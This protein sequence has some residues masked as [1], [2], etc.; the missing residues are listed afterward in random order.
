MTEQDKPYSRNAEILPSTQW[1]E[2]MQRVAL[3]VE[4]LGGQYHGFQ[5]QPSGV[6]TVQQALEHALSQGAAE[7]ITL[8]CAGRTDAGLLGKQQIVGL[9]ALLIKTEDAGEPRRGVQWLMP[10]RG[11]WVRGEGS[12]FLPRV[13][14]KA[15]SSGDVTRDRLT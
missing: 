14:A 9:R 12:E 1:P 5:T 7:P 10:V 13:R 6:P 15:Q 2:G 3:A 4:Y 8:V 11:L